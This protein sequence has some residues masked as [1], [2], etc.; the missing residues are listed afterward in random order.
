MTE[1]R[2]F[3]YGAPL[4][5]TEI[6]LPSAWTSPPPEPVPSQVPPREGG[7]APR[8][9]VPSPPGSR[10]LGSKR[11]F[12]P[13][14]A[15]FIRAGRRQNSFRSF[16]ALWW[17]CG[18]YLRPQALPG[19]FAALQRSHSREP[20]LPQSFLSGNNDPQESCYFWIMNGLEICA[21]QLTESQGSLL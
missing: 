8:L 4:T 19:C 9:Q 21:L 6:K 1:A 7:G 13:T 10:L 3:A 2:K 17:G 18:I 16:S 5:V 15:P 11:V 14:G 20:R 12:V